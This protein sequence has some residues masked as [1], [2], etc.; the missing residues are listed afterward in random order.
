[1]DRLTR[2]K[3]AAE[4]AGMREGGAMLATVL[5]SLR[6]AA[7]PGVTT[8][9]LAVMAR[10]ELAK[11]G[12]E[13]AFEGF[14]GYPDVLCVSINDAIVHG[15]PDETRLSPGDVLSLDFGVRYRGLIT[16]AAISLIVGHPRDRHDA[17]LVAATEAALLAG[18]AVV[19]N[20]AHIGDIG[21]AVESVLHE[22]RL[23]VVRELVGHGVGDELHEAPNIPNFGQA[24]TGL[25]LESGM[26]IAIEP[27]ATRGGHRVHL[28]RDGWTVRSRDG[29]RAAHFE[30]T[31]VVTPTGADILTIT[32]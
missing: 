20:G 30:H 10:R 28:D 19:R 5:A 12:G 15:I 2:R 25:Q 1:M 22:A 17:E 16:D 7:V 21:A 23:G 4:I 6:S 14:N 3:S 29:S 13:P 18:I 11:L 9:E 27:M 24:G 31:V 32:G 8:R 26:T